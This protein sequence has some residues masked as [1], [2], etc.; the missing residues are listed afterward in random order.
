MLI[1]QLTDTKPIEFKEMIFKLKDSEFVEELVKIASFT[2]YFGLFPIR[3]M[4][5]CIFENCWNLR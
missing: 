4:S 1:D 5:T 2:K 3:L